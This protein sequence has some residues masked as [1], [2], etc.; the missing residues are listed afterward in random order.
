MNI[1]NGP[2]SLDVERVRYVQP[3]PNSPG[4][5]SVRA[6]DDRLPLQGDDLVSRVTHEFSY[7]PRAKPCKGKGKQRKHRNYQD[8]S[9]E[10]A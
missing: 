4:G 7:L 8:G 10:W 5:R 3:T 9:C 1:L 2:K 6:S